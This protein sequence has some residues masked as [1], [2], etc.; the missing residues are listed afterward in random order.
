MTPT[1]R[2]AWT[3]PAHR[4]AL[5]ATLGVAIVT[6][7][8]VVLSQQAIG[9]TRTLTGRGIVQSGAGADSIPVFFTV[10]VPNDEKLNG[11][12]G[13]L[14]IGSSTK[15]YQNV[16]QTAIGGKLK[17]VKTKRIRAQ[18]VTADSEVVF[19]G[20]YAVGDKDSVKPDVVYMADRS[21]SACGKLQ[22]ITRRTAAGA[23]LDTLTIEISTST[24]QEKRYE[25][26][27]TKGKDVVFD[28]KDGS[29]FHNAD[30]TLAKP[31]GRVP[32]QAADV[33]ASQQTTGV[34]GE[35][36]GV[37]KLEVKTIDLGVKCQ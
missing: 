35:I 11:E 16:G 33:T 19:K 28:F 14:R 8:A 1:P 34:H 13:E 2:D 15:V 9:A 29:Q 21:F 7:G 30:G 20:R 23:N 10:T 12:K 27:F 36:T 37:N 31:R 22:G 3:S 6:G 18:N 4:T 24:V 17:A 32:I 5:L 26:F 25:R